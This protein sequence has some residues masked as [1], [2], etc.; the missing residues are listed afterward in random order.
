MDG[1]QADVLRAKLK[2][3]D[4]WVER[5]RQIARAYVLGLAAEHNASATKPLLTLPNIEA[6][7]AWH[8]FV[9]RLDN[10][11]TVLAYLRSQGIGAMVHYRTT[12]DGRETEWSR[13][14]IS[15]PI[16]PHLSD[17]H[18]A[19]VIEHVKKAVRS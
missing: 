18:V 8:Q 2:R 9:L 4:A 12:A 6:D 3:L 13:S 5:K 10:R 11:D 1:I 15:L 7:H 17:E 19:Y 14:V 16:H